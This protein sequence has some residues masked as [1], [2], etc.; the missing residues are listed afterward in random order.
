[1][2]S[3][4][5]SS[6]PPRRPYTPPRLVRYGDVAL[7]TR[8]GT[9]VGT[10]SNMTLTT[11]MRRPSSRAY[12]R[13]AARVGEHPMGFGLY[14]FDYKAEFRDRFGHGR[15]FGVIAEEVEQV[16]PEAVSISAD[17][18][19]VVDYARLGIRRQDD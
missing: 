14:L 8:T 16:V 17:G 6:R 9:F 7:L 3:K 13:I 18:L 5:P 4:P 12:K 11:M 2:V 19:R 10:E 1:M 15:Q